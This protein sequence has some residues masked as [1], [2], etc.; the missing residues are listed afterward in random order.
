MHINFDVPD[1]I[2]HHLLDPVPVPP[3]A[4]V[5]YDLPAP[6]PIEEV[7]AA[8]HE[9]MAGIRQAIKPGARIAIGVG[10]RG[11]DRLPEVVAALVRELR[12]LGADPFIVPTMGSHGGATAEGQRAV[13]EH[14]GVTPERVSAPIESQMDTVLLGHT[15]EGAPVLIDRLAMAADG[16]VF[17]ARIKPHTAFHSTYESGLAKMLA[18]GLG[19]QAGAAATHARGFGQMGR[20]VPAMAEVVLQRAPI[21]FAVALLENAHDRIFELHVVPAGRIMADEPELLERARAAMPRIPY[22]QL[23]VLVI[24]EIGKNI[25]GDGAD[26]NITGRYPTPYASGG[27]DVARQVVLDLAEASRGNANGVGTADFTTVRLAGK[28]SLAD[29]YPNALTSTVPRP[30]AL[31]M[32]LPSDRLAI[33]AGILTCNAVDREPR[34]MRIANT[35]KLA[36]FQ[37]SPALLNEARIGPAQVIVEEPQPLDF[38]GDG[39]LRDLGGMW[40]QPPAS[41]SQPAAVLPAQQH[42]AW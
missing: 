38:D 16:I 24:D 37:I 22:P 34:I 27:P 3:M 31:P 8:L 32:V 30:V 2:L 39:N 12:A 26:P 18:I 11:I 25:S 21:L 19:K 1:A 20:M 41:R 42:D 13:L 29:T 14:L 15:A 6:V 17:V 7:A 10:S 36:E 5:R 35:L 28:M 33:A 40:P 23:D 9:Q 4:R